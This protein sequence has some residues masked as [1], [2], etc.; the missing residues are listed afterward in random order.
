MVVEC[1]GKGFTFSREGTERICEALTCLK[2]KVA[3]E[4]A[5]MREDCPFPFEHVDPR[6]CQ[7]PN[8]EGVGLA[9]ERDREPVLTRRLKERRKT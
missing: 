5:K 8:P 9:G 7:R 6:E 1:I 2:D 4:R 3:Q